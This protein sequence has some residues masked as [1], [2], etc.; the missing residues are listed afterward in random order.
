MRLVGPKV[1]PALGV[2]KAWTDL[3]GVIWCFA[4]RNNMLQHSSAK[5]HR[6]VQKPNIVNSRFQLGSRCCDLASQE[7]L[8]F[9]GEVSAMINQESVS[10]WEIMTRKFFHMQ[11]KSGC[12]ELVNFAYHHFSL[13]RL[14]NKLA[15][16]LKKSIKFRHFR[17][18]K[19]TSLSWVSVIEIQHSAFLFSLPSWVIIVI[20]MRDVLVFHSCHASFQL[21]VCLL[22]WFLHVHKRIAIVWGS[23][24]SACLIHHKLFL[25]NYN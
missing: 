4:E 12:G 6:N 2:V 24:N 25:H 8:V 9:I 17:D 21:G 20:K 22:A 13:Y 10:H 19:N 15:S 23:L 11:L 1:G 3:L 18:M 7:G 14:M 5:D 16:S